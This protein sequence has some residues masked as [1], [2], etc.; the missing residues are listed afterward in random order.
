MSGENFSDLSHKA[1]EMLGVAI[2]NIQADEADFGDGIQNFFQLL[3]V[4]RS[5]ASANRYILNEI[6][7]MKMERSVFVAQ[8][9]GR[10]FGL[11]FANSTHSSF[12]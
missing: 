7:V 8:L 2:G 3:E 12:V 9:T 10:A 5:H 6:A 1:D 11:I 4:A